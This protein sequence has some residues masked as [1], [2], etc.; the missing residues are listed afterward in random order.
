MISN[1]PILCSY[2]PYAAMLL[3]VWFPNNF[4]ITTLYIFEI[5]DVSETEIIQLLR[6]IKNENS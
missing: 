3:E 6:K 1:F 2:W 4:E 5:P